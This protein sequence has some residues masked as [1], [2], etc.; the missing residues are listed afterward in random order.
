MINGIHSICWDF[1]T[2]QGFVAQGFHIGFV[3]ANHYVAVMDAQ[4][5]FIDLI[6]SLPA[7]ASVQGQEE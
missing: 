1:Y 5:R 7:R 3:P 6:D 4:V 2:T